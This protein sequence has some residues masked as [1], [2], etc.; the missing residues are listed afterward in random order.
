MSSETT[1]GPRCASVLDLPGLWVPIVTPFDRDGEVDV[2][3][4][5]SLCRHLLLEGATGIVALGTTGEPATLD[6]SEQRSV[7]TTCAAVCDELGRPLMVGT[8][9]NSTRSTVAAVRSLAGVPSVV[10]TL[11]VVPYYTRPSVA[12]IVEH[13]RAVAEASPVPVVLY[14]VPYRTGR[15]LDAE[16]ILEIASIPNVAGLKQSVACL[17]ADTLEILRRAP[18]SFQVLCGDD[19]FIAPITLLGGA[20]A[21]AASSHVCTKEFAQLVAASLEGDAPTARRLAAS[22]LPVVTAGFAEPN[23]AVFKA[24]LHAAGLLETAALRAPMAAAGP[25]STRRILDAIAAAVIA[26]ALPDMP[27]AIPG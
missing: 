14:N 5:A 10:A 23:P 27:E 13:V 16:T 21:I 26:T 3:S 1:P 15:G 25:D 7:I 4:L 11:V 12:A 22:L 19:A 2:V 18:R 8:G 17:D 6:A 20:G 9:T 24:A